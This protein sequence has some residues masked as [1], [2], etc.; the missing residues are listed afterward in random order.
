MVERE[1]H[2]EAANLDVLEA[3]VLVSKLD[4]EERKALAAWHTSWSGFIVNHPRK[5]ESRF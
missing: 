5:S 4:V 1:M 2:L 3:P